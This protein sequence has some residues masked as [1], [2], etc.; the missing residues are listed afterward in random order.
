[1]LIDLLLTFWIAIL[2]R[3]ILTD[4]FVSSGDLFP[5][6]DV[7]RK[8]DLDFEKIIRKSILGLRLQPEDSFILKVRRLFF[9][10][11]CPGARARP[12]LL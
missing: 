4:I 12:G 1:M 9:K 6:L 2:G 11:K 7:P 10:K 8:R 5:S 3:N